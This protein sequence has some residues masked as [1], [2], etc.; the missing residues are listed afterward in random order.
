[1]CSEPTCS[2]QE[3]MQ[4]KPVK[5]TELSRRD[6]RALIFHLLY[7]AEAYEYQDSLQAIVDNLNRGFQLDIPFDSE[8]V[9]TAQAIIDMRDQL[10]QKYIALLDNWRPE[11]V[12]VCTK[13]I[14]RLGMWELIYTDTDPRI[15]I[16]EAIELAKCFA[17]ADA[18]R[19]INGLLDRAVKQG[20]YRNT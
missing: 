5:Y 6:I 2:Q 16:N 4:D 1:M 19:F 7:A 15:I 18:Y 3:A 9:Q 20:S 13:L 11:R 8:A 17:E 10:D 12:S 14:L